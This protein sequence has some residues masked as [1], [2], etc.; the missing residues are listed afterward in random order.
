M[1]DFCTNVLNGKQIEYND[2]TKF[3]SEC[4]GL[5]KVEYDG[6][7]IQQLI[8]FIQMGAVDLRE[9]IKAYCA[10]KNYIINTLSSLKDN[11]II[12]VWIEE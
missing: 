4:F 2:L 9:A 12:K 8:Q 5:D 7:K 11:R 10:R 1:K 3:I 6:T